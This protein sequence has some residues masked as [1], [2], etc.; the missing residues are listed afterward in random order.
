MYK[1]LMTAAMMVL[2]L[3]SISAVAGDADYKYVGVKKCKTCHKSKKSGNQFGVWKESKHANAYAVLASDKSKAKAKEM[4][5]EDPQKSEKCLTCHTTAYGKDKQWAKSYKLEEGVGCEGCHGPGSKY[6]SMKVMKN[7]EMA[8]SKGL[9][10]P[11]EKT[12]V[13]C[14][15]KDNPFHKEFKYKEFFAKIAHPVPAKK[16]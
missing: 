7:K 15:N 2:F 1:T 11:D 8:V 4:G 16:K 12:C 3:M 10:I 5:I 6:K 13:K 9:V 14:H